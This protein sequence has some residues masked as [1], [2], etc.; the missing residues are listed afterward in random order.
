MQ[1][2]IKADLDMMPSISLLSL[3]LLP[4]VHAFYRVPIIARDLANTL[5]NKLPLFPFFVFDVSELE[6]LQGA[7]LRGQVIHAL[8]SAHVHIGTLRCRCCR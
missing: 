8:S 6:R 2:N 7:Q 3:L 5:H 4:Y 1:P